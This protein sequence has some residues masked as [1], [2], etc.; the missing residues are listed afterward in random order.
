[1][2]QI[3]AVSFILPTCFGQ[4]GPL[5]GR[6]MYLCMENDASISD[7]AVYHKYISDSGLCPV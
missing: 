3:R 7:C 6:I 2:L 1:M 5:P 4:A